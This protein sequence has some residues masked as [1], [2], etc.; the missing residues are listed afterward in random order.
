MNLSL[1]QDSKFNR[2]NCYSSFR[3]CKNFTA[4]NNFSWKTYKNLIVDYTQ[5]FRYSN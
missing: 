1:H 5:G 2:G 4:N 3:L